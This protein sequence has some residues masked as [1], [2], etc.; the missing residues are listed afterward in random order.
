MPQNIEF[1]DVFINIVVIEERNQALMKKA[2]RLVEKHQNLEKET[3]LD[4]NKSVSKIRTV[5]EKTVM[6]STKIE[7]SQE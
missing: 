5:E 7:S 3:I 6:K 1:Q 2:N 4:I